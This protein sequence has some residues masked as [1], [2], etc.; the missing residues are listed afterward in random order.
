MD[1]K[2]CTCAVIGSE[3]L[4]GFEMGPFRINI[5]CMRSCEKFGA[6]YVRR[7]VT[8]CH[9]ILYNSKYLTHYCTIHGRCVVVQSSVDSS[10]TSLIGLCA[11]GDPGLLH[12]CTKTI[13]RSSLNTGNG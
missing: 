12:K 8:F 3:F 4:F 2:N 6:R 13:V 1:C 9:Y 11:E 10:F 7:T 5:I